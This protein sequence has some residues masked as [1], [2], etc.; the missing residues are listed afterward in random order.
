MVALVVIGVQGE[1][2]FGT[3]TSTS[4]LL[5]L[6]GLLQAVFAAIYLIMRGPD[7]E[8]IH[9]DFLLADALIAKLDQLDWHLS[10]PTVIIQ[11]PHDSLDDMDHFFRKPHKG[12]FDHYYSLPNAL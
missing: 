6:S 12:D 5:A 1:L 2:V 3:R 4:V 11:P 8:L 7:G 10:L 9:D